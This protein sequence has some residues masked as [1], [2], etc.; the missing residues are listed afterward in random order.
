MLWASFK[1]R[2]PVPSLLV[3]GAAWGPRLLFVFLLGV[4]CSLGSPVE[5][6]GPVA[7]SFPSDAAYL[8]YLR[9]GVVRQIG[10]QTAIYEQEIFDVHQDRFGF[11]WV[12]TVF[13][14]FR[15]DGKEFV[16][17]TPKFEVDESTQ[18]RLVFSMDEEKDGTLWFCSYDFLYRY[19][20]VSDTVKAVENTRSR[21]VRI[22]PFG[23]IC[24]LDSRGGFHVYRYD[25]GNLVEVQDATLEAVRSS[26]LFASSFC[27][28]G[29]RG[30]LLVG[31]R[32]EL[33]RLNV[34]G[35]SFHLP[36]NQ[37]PPLP[38][39]KKYK[40]TCSLLEGQ[41]LWV[42][43]TPDGLYRVDLQSGEVVRFD[44]SR[45]GQR[46][47][48]PGNRIAW[49]ERDPFDRVWS[50]S[51][52]AGLA[53]Y[54]PREERFETVS[55]DKAQVSRE[56]RIWPRSG[57]VD[58]DGSIWLGS[59]DLGL[60]IVDTNPA[61]FRYEPL[62][63]QNGRDLG[64]DYINCYLQ[65]SDGTQWM[66][67]RGEG[68]C[69]KSGGV[70]EVDVELAGVSRNASTSDFISLEEDKHGRIWIGSTKGRVYVYDPK[71]LSCQELQGL[72]LRDVF[73]GSL[74]A[75]G[76]DMWVGSEN[77]L[78]RVDID[79]LKVVEEVEGI[80]S[81]VRSI[82]HGPNGLIWI[83]CQFGLHIYDPQLKGLRTWTDAHG[84]AQRVALEGSISDVIFNEDGTAWVASYGSGLRLVDGEFKVLSQFLAKD[85]LLSEAFA[86]IQIDAFGVLWAATRSGV[87]ALDL[88]SGET[89]FYS[90]EDGLQ[91]NRFEIKRSQKRADG[92]LVFPSTKGLL[93]VRPECKGRPVAPL[94]PRLTSVQVLGK[95]VGVDD[96]S[97]SLDKAILLADSLRLS[98]G[99]SVFAISYSAMNYKSLGK[100]WFRHRMLGVSADWSEPTLGN[101]ASFSLPRSGEYRLEV[102]ASSDVRIWDGPVRQLKVTLVPSL[103]T[104]WWMILG[105]LGLLALVIYVF[106]SVRTRSLQ[107][108]RRELEQIVERRTATIEERNKEILAQNAELEASRVQLE[109]HRC[110]LEAMVEER[111]RDLSEA[112]ERAERA[113]MLKS[114]FLA[115]MS[116][117]IRTPLNAVVGFSQILAD[118]ERRDEN[119]QREYKKII[120]NAA[121]GLTHLIDDILDLSK[122]ESGQLNVELEDFDLLE[123]AKVLF[124]EYK[125]RVA[126]IPDVELRL[127]YGDL[128]VLPV[129]ADPYRTR[130]I[131]VNFLDNALKF[132]SEGSIEII[133]T[134]VGEEAVARIKDSG[135]GIPL[136]SQAEVFDRFRKLERGGR[137]LFR[138]AGLGLAISKKLAELIGGVIELESE[139]GKGSIFSLRLPIVAG[140]ALLKPEEGL[141]TKQRYDWSGKTLLVAEDEDYNYLL[142]EELVRSTGVSVERARNGLEVVDKI[143]GGLPVDAILMDLQM[144][145]M[146]GFEALDRIREHCSGVRVVAHTAHSLLYNRDAM[147][148]RGFDE[149]LSK[150]IDAD[151]ALAMIDNLLV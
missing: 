62:I 117:E 47:S 40:T 32:G 124:V 58:R 133:V 78:F 67:I 10:P 100:T 68:L 119:L 118:M 14:L 97:G 5:A 87:F 149:Y 130:Q 18:H 151:R 143:R 101:R 29:D 134:R 4:W 92:S 26:G 103:W 90:K 33:L 61:L 140:A 6:K 27:L 94:A 19:D 139:P 34:A 11:I 73:V 111:T 45:Q 7:S 35:D 123:L 48:H 137:K 83:G 105:I 64:G 106:T 122:L 76:D 72:R 129:R 120:K 24:V 145:E 74:R 20:R 138:G 121:A 110:H 30:V 55:Y 8:D 107:A 128:I 136:E 71:S 135:V 53:V 88:A 36:V 93:T 51:F 70:F 115:N 114:A 59:M 150:P 17:F 69:R 31:Q 65:A 147:L 144:P 37:P 42:G 104:R 79:S 142:V 43:T 141:Q 84:G 81:M 99:H 91:G 146:D 12:A 109:E 116:H 50:G 56:G 113:D 85:G 16:D 38:Q 89:N 28:D 108:R 44:A 80:D 82:S 21:F 98:P 77:S 15:Y 132:T 52:D 54:L 63:D 1:N 9:S 96:D 102:Q 95:E 126:D 57:M 60:F 131:L 23:R 86:S 66:G 75:I 49:L 25:G 125:E 41:R 22:D 39:G 46:L 112:K 13:K 3:G 127:D 148:S 2:F